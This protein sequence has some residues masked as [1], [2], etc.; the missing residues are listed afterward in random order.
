[1]EWM[2]WVWLG[3]TAMSLLIEF[4]T[5]EM[6]SIW[7]VAG[8]IICMILAACGVGWEIQLIVFIV[9]SLILLLSLRK[10][11]LKFLIKKD[12][13]K[14]NADSVIGENYK[15]LTPITSDSMGTIKING[16]IWNV[17]TSNNSELDA[18]ET[19]EIIKISGNKY[20][21]KKGENK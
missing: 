17:V 18:G 16:V 13:T 9:V 11:A 8:G 15:L 19:I 6:A 14:T 4:T 5:M 3:V 2:I 10:I 1:M 20:V 12:N 21:V 7:F